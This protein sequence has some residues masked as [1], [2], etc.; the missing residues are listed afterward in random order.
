MNIGIIGCGDIAR[1]TANTISE[2]DGI[3]THAVA[4]RSADKAAEF[5]EEV[6]AANSYGSYAELINDPDVD[7]VYIATPHPHHHEWGIAALKTGKPVLCEKPMALNAKETEDLVKTARTE[8]IFLMEAI[9]SRFIEPMA[10]IR[11]CINSGKIGD[12]RMVQADTGYRV[13]FNPDSRLFR[14]DLAG[15]GLMDIGVYGVSR[16]VQFLGAPTSQQSIAELG[17]TGVDEHCVITTMHDNGAIGIITAGIRTQTC[18]ELTIYGTDGRI[19]TTNAFNSVTLTQNGKEDEALTFDMTHR[20]APMLLEAKRCL[21]EGLTESPV[22]PL[23]HSL[24][25]A[26]I[27]NS[28]RNQWG[29]RYPGE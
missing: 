18:G 12:I 25:I 10:F 29:L 21:A 13:P 19:R 3:T 20:R 26:Q 4:S 1:K 28:A 17:A 14:P 15:G 11:D 8:N 27:M 16:I 24:T 6:G 23:D 2:T 5:A 22:M 9:W 7:L